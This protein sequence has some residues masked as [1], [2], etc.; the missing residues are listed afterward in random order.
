MQ[1]DNYT[2]DFI[3]YCLSMIFT[4]AK[5]CHLLKQLAAHVKSVNV[6]LYS[7][8]ANNGPVL[9]KTHNG[10]MSNFGGHHGQSTC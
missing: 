5:S 8:D 10:D 1:G 2:A 9:N 7:L 3:E 6:I 4:D